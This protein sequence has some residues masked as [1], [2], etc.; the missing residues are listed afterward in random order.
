MR[1]HGARTCLASTRLPSLIGVSARVRELR[2][3]SRGS[4]LTQD[5][6]NETMMIT[7]GE[8]AAGGLARLS[9]R[10]LRSR[11]RRLGVAACPLGLV[12][13][14]ADVPRHPHGYVR[15][16]RTMRQEGRCMYHV[17]L[18]VTCP[19]DAMLFYGIM[20]RSMAYDVMV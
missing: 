19:C 15:N 16:R 5:L 3:P 10:F 12:K 6:K 7:I 8:A 13:R 17:Y 1:G 14:H 18:L 20:Y 2:V 4:A 9:L 11:F